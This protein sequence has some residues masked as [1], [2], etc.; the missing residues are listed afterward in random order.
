MLISVR[1]FNFLITSYQIRKGKFIPYG[2]STRESKI[3]TALLVYITIVLTIG[4]YKEINTIGFEA[5][6]EY[7]PIRLWIL[8]ELASIFYE[9]FFY[10]LF[11]KAIN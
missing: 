9:P 3:K 6:S 11:L 8:I 10:Y 2:F 1:I 4:I 7:K 5:I